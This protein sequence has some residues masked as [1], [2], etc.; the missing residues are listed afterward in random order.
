MSVSFVADVHIHNHRKFGGASVA[1]LNSRCTEILEAL[2]QAAHAGKSSDA[3]IVL[4]DLFDTTKPTPQVIARVMRVLRDGNP[5]TLL[6]VG[7]HDQV[8]TY[9]GDHAMAPLGELPNVTVVERSK[10]FIESSATPLAVV[11]FRPGNAREWLPE[12]LAKLGDLT[13]YTVCIHLGIM[14]GKT[15]K[16]LAAAH[17]AIHVDQLRALQAEFNFRRVLAGNWHH[18]YIWE[19]QEPKLTVVQTGALVP[20][21]FDN[22]G[23]EGYGTVG[24][25]NDDETVHTEE[26]PGPRFVK[27]KSV[28]EVQAACDSVG[29]HV[30]VRLV[31]PPNQV[32]EALKVRQSKFSDFPFIEVLPDEK[33]ARQAARSAAVS[34]RSA[35]TLDEALSAYVSRMAMPE[36][37]DPQD[38]I[39][40]AK[41]Y[42]GGTNG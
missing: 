39:Q 37:L 11:P 8:S 33:I 19:F 20:T 2:E 42:L 14:D 34:A 3:F 5:N 30:R 38:V 41:N 16:F 35:D 21:G 7:N 27:C 10:K 4:G 28:E 9:S 31:V 22:P 12:E 13:G 6:L 26:I 23:L 24:T 36:G 40:L 1:G 25:V 29:K 32:Q 18:K 17:D 15:P